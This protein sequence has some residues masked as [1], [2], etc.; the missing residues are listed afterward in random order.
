MHWHHQQSAS[1][2]QTLA[3]L[4]YFNDRFCPGRAQ[5]SQLCWGFVLLG[6]VRPRD[7][8]DTPA[9]DA[10]IAVKR[11][12][13]ALLATSPHSTTG[14]HRKASED[15]THQHQHNK[16]RRSIDSYFRIS[17]G[18]DTPTSQLRFQRCT[19][20]Q[21]ISMQSIALHLLK[22]TGIE[23]TRISSGKVYRK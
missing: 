3:Q 17:G 7:E 1:A 13:R 14:S 9:A 19:M 4:I 16:R 18:W 20:A 10:A 2:E 8:C 15:A 23:R 12:Q 22:Q 6:L 21:C 11:A 5:S